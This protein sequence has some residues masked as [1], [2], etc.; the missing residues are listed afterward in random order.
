[1]EQA[2][3]QNSRKGFLYFIWK[4]LP[5]VALLALFLIVWLLFGAISAKKEEIEAG[6][7]EAHEEYKKPVNV[8]LLRLEEQEVDDV[9]NLPGTIEAW[10]NLTLSAKVNGTIE[11]VMV[12]E[13]D[14]VNEGELLAQIEEEDYIIALD[15]AKAAYTLARSEHTRNQAMLKKK[16]ISS[17]SLET[18][19]A[20]LLNTRARLKE[21][22]LRLSRCRITSPIT[23]VIKH[24]DAKV[25][26]FVSVGDPL[27]RLLELDRVKAVV[28]IPE[29]DVDAVRNVDRVDFTLSALQNKNFTARAHFLSPSPDSTAFLY[30]FEL[31]V[32]NPDHQILPGMFVRA[33]IIKKHF[34]KALMI[35]L[36]SIVS[37]DGEQY[38]YV[39][40]GE[41]ARRQHIKVGIIDKWKIQ[42][43][44]GLHPGDKV[45]VEGQRDVEDG[46]SIHA[47]KVVTDRN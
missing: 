38:V 27:A 18:S 37:R 13:G 43:V 22:E 23:G 41:R 7:K 44:E 10:T 45:V 46:Q 3:R 33:H 40:D 11:Q 39:A 9:I 16:V 20:N 28:G 30:R 5:L 26:A 42:V 8:V 2:K 32:A 24:L 29:S 19:K 25:G 31:A 17:A 35:P 36:Y 1:M 47:V 34:D 14:R 21:A 4:K 6:K 12:Q 15:A